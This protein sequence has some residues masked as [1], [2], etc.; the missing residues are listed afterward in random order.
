VWHTNIVT[1]VLQRADENAGMLLELPAGGREVDS[2]SAALT[3]FP[4]AAT[5]RKVR[6][7]SVSKGGTLR[8]Y[9]RYFRY[10]GPFL[11]VS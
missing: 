5:V 1:R 9:Y 10:Q 8:K 7:S 11:I 3:K 4:A 2:A 6:P